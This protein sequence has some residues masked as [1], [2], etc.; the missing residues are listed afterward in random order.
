MNSLNL[1]RLTEPSQSCVRTELNMALGVETANW[2]PGSVSANELYSLLG[3]VGK[4][5]YNIVVVRELEI[6]GLSTSE[7]LTQKLILTIWTVLEWPFLKYPQLRSS[8]ARKTR[9]GCKQFV[10]S[11]THNNF[12]LSTLDGENRF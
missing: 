5:V 6:D 11:Y 4:L 2:T 9:K 12:L 7:N 1:I 3:C 8:R 10:L